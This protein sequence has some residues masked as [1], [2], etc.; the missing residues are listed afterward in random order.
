MMMLWALCAPV[1]GC[2]LLVDFEECSAN[3]DCEAGSVCADGICQAPAGPKACVK[4][5]D[6][7]GEANTYCFV[8]SCRTVDTNQCEVKGAAFAQAASTNIVPVGVLLSTSTADGIRAQAGVRGAQLALDQI[9]AQSGLASGKFGLVVCDTEFKAEVAVAK[10]RYAAEELGIKAF[11]G[12][13]GS[14]ESLEVANQVAI[15]RGL[16][17]V[18]PASTSPALTGLNDTNL[19]W[20]TVASDALQGPAMAKLVK[21]GGFNK[22]ALLSVA[23]AYGEG[24]RSVIQDYWATNEPTLLTDA[25]RYRSLQ[26]SATDFTGEIATIGEQLFG[27]NGF[28]PDA[29]VLIGTSAALELI[30]SLESLYVSKLPDKERPVWIGS[31]ATKAPKILEPRF[32]DVWPRLQG[33]VIQQS[34]TPLYAQFSADYRAA[35]MSDPTTFPMADKAYDGAFLIALAYAVQSDLKAA[36]GVTLAQVLGRVSSG[37]RLQAKATNFGQMATILIMGGS[38]N[39]E[40]VSGPLD[41][42]AKGD[43]FGDIASW[44]VE[45]S[46]DGKTAMFKDG[47]VIP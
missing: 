44:S 40:G 22:I 37:S 39:I 32:A 31:E 3:A 25:N 23:N 11:V 36:T 8:G 42:D 10:A 12:A 16:L 34:L 17:M 5:S 19:V 13:Q 27:A 28:K 33:T 47:A 24:F 38:V 41:F 6:C 18:S 15:P 35:Y 4:G 29:V 30:A 46:M 20:R 2:S 26:F 7:G 21:Q 9:N 45:V 1:S 43:V 14:S